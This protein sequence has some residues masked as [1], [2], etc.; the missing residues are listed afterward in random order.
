ML[1]SAPSAVLIEASF[2]QQAIDLARNGGGQFLLE[3]IQNNI[4]Y[5]LGGGGRNAGPF[6]NEIHNFVHIILLFEY[7]FIVNR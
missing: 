5:R 7:Q 6:D 2:F 1:P 3:E 4:D